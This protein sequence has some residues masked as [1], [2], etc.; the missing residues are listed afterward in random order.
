MQPHSG[1]GHAIGLHVT[2]RRARLMDPNTSEYEFP[3]HSDL[4]TFLPKYLDAL[5]SACGFTTY[6]YYFFN[7]T[8]TQSAELADDGLASVLPKRV[9]DLVID[10]IY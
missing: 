1:T 9:R 3:T 6:Q 10:Y 4:L 2:A 5:Y 7:D 8:V